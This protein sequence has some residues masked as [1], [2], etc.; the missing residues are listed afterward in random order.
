MPIRLRKN[1]IFYALSAQEREVA[2]QLI[3][4]LSGNRVTFEIK[5]VRDEVEIEQH[6]HLSAIIT[7]LVKKGFLVRVSRGKYRFKSSARVRCLRTM[8][9]L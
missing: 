2:I 3:H 6:S 5:D 7:R 8:E 1:D 9:W 4:F